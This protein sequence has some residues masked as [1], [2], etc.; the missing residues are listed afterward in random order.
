MQYLRKFQLNEVYFKVKYPNYLDDLKVY[1]TTQQ[2]LE[3]Q[4]KAVHKMSSEIE[5]TLRECKC[6][7]DST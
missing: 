5:I 3:N 6:K 2:E 4:L 1:V 7:R